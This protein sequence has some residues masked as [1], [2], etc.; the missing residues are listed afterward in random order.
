[1]QL[2]GPPY[3][4]LPFIQK[5]PLSLQQ[6]FG[7]KVF[8]IA[9]RL[10]VSPN[11]LMIVMNNESGLNPRAKNPNSSATGLIQFLDST[12]LGLGTSTGKLAQMNAVDQLEYVYQ[13]FKTYK[14]KINDVADAYQAVFYP[15]ALN[16]PDSFVYPQVVAG[17]NPIFDLNR[18]STL[19][20]GEFRQYVNQKYSAILN[21]EIELW[22]NTKKKSKSLPLS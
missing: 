10:G 17:L 4:K 20:K 1:M 16:K 14:G 12:A 2:F 11:W 13:Y 7:E 22:Y 18:D 19:T 15:A 6:A 8:D 21:N 5:V 9:N 3:S